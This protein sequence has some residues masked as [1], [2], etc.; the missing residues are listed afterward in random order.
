MNKLLLILP[1]SCLLFFSCKKE[2]E[3]PEDTQP[4][5]FFENLAFNSTNAYFSTDGSMSAPV[6]AEKAK[7]IA[8]K[9]D[10]TF[11]YDYD[12]SQPGFFDP[13]ARSEEYYWD[14]FHQPWLEVAVETRFYVTDLSKEQFDATKKDDALISKYFADN[15]F[16]LA[17]HSIF[18]E[19]SCIG[20]RQSGEGATVPL[21]TGAV[22]GF[23]NTSSGKKGLLYIRTDQPSA[24]PYVLMSPDTKV[25]IIRER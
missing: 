9:I 8:E 24:W 14:N 5:N 1:L 4:N 19:G 23:E 25:D 20:G 13:V 15:D 10:I 2:E 16:S 11:I 12:Y 3:E 17:P 6:D 21:A 22:F 7:E 18:P